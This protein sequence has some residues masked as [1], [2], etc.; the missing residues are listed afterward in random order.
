MFSNDWRNVFTEVVKGDNLQ[1]LL[2][3][4]A[5]SG[6]LTDWTRGLTTAVV[7]SFQGMGWEASAKG[8]KATILPVARSEYLSLDVVAFRR[9]DK[10]WAFPVA[11]AELENSRDEDKIAYS[12][13]KVM[14]IRADFRLVFCYR[15]QVSEIPSLISHLKEKVVGSMALTDRAGFSGETVLVV[16]HRGDAEIFPYGYFKWW[17]LDANT[18]S[19]SLM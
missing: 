3:V 2:R 7:K 15:D 16:G 10:H 6:N 19:L 14:C 1:D 9:S 17:I 12:L 8:N 11:V 13:W 4:A 18:S 5:T